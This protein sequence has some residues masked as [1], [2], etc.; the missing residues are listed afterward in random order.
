[1]TT[2][3]REHARREGDHHKHCDCGYMILICQVI[4][5][6]HI[7]KELCE[8]MGESLS[9]WSS[10]SGDIK[11]LTCHLTLIEASSNF[12]SGSLS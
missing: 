1:M 4:S 9:H 6:G 11:Y 3:F 7:L 12:M 5:C 10:A 8:Y 2:S